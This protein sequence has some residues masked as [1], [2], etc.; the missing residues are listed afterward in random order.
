[1]EKLK[2]KPIDPLQSK[3]KE[4]RPTTPAYHKYPSDMKYRLLLGICKTNALIKLNDD[5]NNLTRMIKTQ[6]PLTLKSAK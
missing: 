6:K 1:M 3:T 4:I 5:I 2:L